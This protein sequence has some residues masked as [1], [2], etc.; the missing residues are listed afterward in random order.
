MSG[1]DGSF[2]INIDTGNT[3]LYNCALHLASF[4]AAMAAAGSHRH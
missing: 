4:T 2:E 3:W 1:V